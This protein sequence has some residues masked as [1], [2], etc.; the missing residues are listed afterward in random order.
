MKNKVGSFIKY[1]PIA[2]YYLFF[3]SVVMYIK[4]HNQAMTETQLLINF[5][6][7]WAVLVLT[8]VLASYLLTRLL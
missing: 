3:I 8:T 4:L 7:V 2:M 1:F 6:P 5:W